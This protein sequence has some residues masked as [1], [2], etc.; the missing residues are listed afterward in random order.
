MEDKQKRQSKQ[1]DKNTQKIRLPHPGILFVDISAAP[2]LVG[3]PR[4]LCLLSMENKLAPALGIQG[5]VLFL[6][7]GQLIRLLRQRESVPMLDGG[8]DIP[9]VCVCVSV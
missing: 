3:T 7:T 8:S 4:L 6:L 5:L 9:A 2:R 1:T